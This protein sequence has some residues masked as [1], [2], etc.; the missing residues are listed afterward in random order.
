MTNETDWDKLSDE[1]AE[2]TPDIIDETIRPQRSIT[3]DDLDDIFA[4]RPS[5]RSPAPRPTCSTRRT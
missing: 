3:M 1:Y 2:H 5:L 4:G